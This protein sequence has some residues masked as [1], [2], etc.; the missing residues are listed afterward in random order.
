MNNKEYMTL[1]SEQS[2]KNKVCTC[3]LSQQSVKMN[4]EKKK[5]KA[6]HEQNLLFAI[7]KCLS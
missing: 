3:R 5:L 4:A 6:L 7:S 2:E 1:E